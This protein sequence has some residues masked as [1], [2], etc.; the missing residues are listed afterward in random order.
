MTRPLPHERQTARQMAAQSDTPM[1]IAGKPA[2]KCPYCG[3]GMFV[4]RTENLQTRVERYEN[5]RIC[6][7]TFIT[8]QPQKVFVRE[9][10]SS[11]SEELSAAGNHHLTLRRESG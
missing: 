6:K 8:H 5:C 1:Q 9:V 7:K 11:D 10:P 2:V 4:Y 3:A